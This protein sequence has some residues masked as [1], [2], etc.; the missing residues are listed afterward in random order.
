MV[1]KELGK[2][3]TK[4][5][6]TC[7]KMASILGQVRSFLIAL[8]FLRAFTDTLC[9]FVNVSTEKGWNFLQKLPSNLKDQLKEI[10][11]LLDNWGGGLFKKSTIKN[12]TPIPQ[13]KLGGIRSKKWSICK[14]LLARGGNFT[15]KCKGIESRNCNGK[16]FGQTQ[17]N[18]SFVG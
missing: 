13:P 14:G 9:Q 3:V 4:D 5:Q 8:P 2:L 16:K 18:N 10:K 17:A 11:V 12:C 1:K 15:Y 6:L 7:R